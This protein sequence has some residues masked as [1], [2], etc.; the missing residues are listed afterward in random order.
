MSR[1]TAIDYDDEDSWF[2]PQESEPEP[3]GNFSD[4]DSC[5]DYDDDS[6]FG[7]YAEPIYD[8]RDHWKRVNERIDQRNAELAEQHRR[9]MRDLR[10][11]RC[12]EPRLDGPFEWSDSYCNRH[13]A[14]DDYGHYA[15]AFDSLPSKAGTRRAILDTHGKWV[16]YPRYEF[17]P[18]RGTRYNLHRSKSVLELGYRSYDPDRSVRLSRYGKMRKH[19][20]SWK[21]DRRARQ[22]QNREICRGL[23]PGEREIY[24]QEVDNCYRFILGACTPKIEG[25]VACF[26]ILIWREVFPLRCLKG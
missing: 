11:N 6:W 17:G 24:A 25:H 8:Y 1:N 10:E 13:D 23:D 12:E 5:Y 7:A 2:F 15:D 4:E 22:W 19:R 9:Q 21:R 26:F 20:M 14:E 16:E 3:F 18:R